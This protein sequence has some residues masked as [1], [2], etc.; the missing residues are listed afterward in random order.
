MPVFRSFRKPLLAALATL[1]AAA[2]ILYS[3][4]WT[5][6]GNRTQPV[7]LGFNNTFVL[8]RHCQLVRSVVSGS[9]AERSGLKPGDCII[10]V[11]ST[12]MEAEDSLTRIWAKHKPGDEVELTVQRAGASDPLVVQA[13]F[14]A[15]SSASGEAG[16]AQHVGQSIVNLYPLAFLTVG[17]AVLFLRLDDPN[18]WLLALMFAGFIAIP[19]FG[20]SFLDVPTSLRPLA[21]AYRAIFNNM[22]GAFFYFFF[23][24]FPTQSPLDRRLP[25][26]KWLA[27]MLGAAL[28][29]PVLWASG[30]GALGGMFVGYG[31]VLVLFFDYGLI[32]LGLV[33]L[34][35]NAVS[36]D[37]AEA[38]RK[39]RVI[40]W[41][42]LVGCVPATL[43]L[44]A[45]DFFGFHI[46]LWIVV[47]VVLLLWLFPLSFAYALIKHR[48]LEVP[49]LLQRGARYLLVQRGFAV[50]LVLLSVGVTLA[51]ALFF[52]RYLQPLT[53]VAV[54]GGI[55]LG[56]V[57]GTLLLWSGVQVHKDVGKRID[58]AFFRNAYDARIILEDLLEK[59]RTATD[60]KEL[61]ALLEHHLRDALQPSSLVVYL[62]A[63]DDQLLVMAGHAP[64]EF[65]V[66]SATDATFGELV[67][68]GRP[69]EVSRDGPNGGP[70][71]LSFG[72]L[73]ADC[74][75]PILGRDSRLVGLVVL[76]QR[77]S[78]EP[79][80]SE[81]KH[82]L[83]SVASQA[84]VALESI[85]LGEKVAERIE[86]ERRTAQEMEFA[87]Q[88]QSRLFP[89]KLPAMKTLEYVGG[90]IPAR[91]VGGDYYDFLELR[92]GRLA[93]VLAD[94]AGKG[95][96]G[97]LLMANLQAN[98]RSQYAMA[99]DD[100][101][102][103]L[104]S[105]NRLFY[106][107]TDVA[108]YATLFFADYDDSSR[109]LRYA[110]C[111]HLPPLL[112]RAGGSSPVEWLGSTSTVMGLFE[113]WHC[114]IAEVQLAPGD[115]L[116]LYTDGIT[117]AAN[118]HG[119]EFGECH[120]LDTLKSHSDLPVPLLLQAVVGAVQQFSGGSEQQDDITVV[121]ARSLA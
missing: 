67:R 98:V 51:F 38:R 37:S 109:K 121:I 120:L 103:L 35:W 16:A 94:I 27:L 107:S 70:T 22:A 42:T 49:V 83:A 47:T 24:I 40:L 19:N 48:V 63:N 55:G 10:R 5:L 39:I 1:F 66:I 82:L 50:L 68:H 28:A 18:A 14:R 15:S 112:L 58:R 52:A 6:Y 61:A 91:T 114:E 99:I 13:T 57:F 43:E 9:P 31:H 93:L 116:V 111:G 102:R 80:S 72:P 53:G 45:S 78:E 4:L 76:G 56:T 90:C 3:G 30:G 73:Q 101:P 62:E 20:N 71:R 25:W 11:N 64:A 46:T 87:R 108:S 32:V 113:A 21:T 81:D 100:L 105:I 33:S 60:R 2:T 92:P 54:P 44:A 95:V 41:G 29:L 77:L 119:E 69:W 34:T 23:A 74:L 85:R 117:E 8:A 36:V 79:Y 12:L 84:G 17:L 86:A 96:S 118:A 75:V 65:E 115:M 97:A 106:E 26:L 89:Q 104:A 7:E 110:N 88:V 59:T